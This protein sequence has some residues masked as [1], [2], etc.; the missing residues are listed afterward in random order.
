VESGISQVSARWVPCDLSSDEQNRK[1][2]EVC[3]QKVTLAEKK[4]LVFL[5]SIIICDESWIRL[6]DPE[7]K[8]QSSVQKHK[9]SPPKIFRTAQPSQ[10]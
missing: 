5:S 3:H 1:C 6:Y 4:T 7:S 10:N 9:N 2:V 8:Q